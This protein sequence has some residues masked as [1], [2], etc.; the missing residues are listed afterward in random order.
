MNLKIQH[1]RNLVLLPMLFSLLTLPAIGSDS[2]HVTGAIRLQLAFSGLQLTMITISGYTESI[3]P[4]ELPQMSLQDKSWKKNM[5]NISDTESWIL[6]LGH[7]E[8]MPA[9]ALQK[10]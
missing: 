10:Q 4:N 6:Q 1:F 7:D 9:L 2:E 8:G 3:I 5:M